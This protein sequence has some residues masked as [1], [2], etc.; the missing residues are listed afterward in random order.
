MSLGIDSLVVFLDLQLVVS[1]LNN[2][3]HVRDPFLHRLFLQVR[4]L[5]HSFHY[6]TFIHIPHLDNWYA[7]SLANQTIDWDINHSIL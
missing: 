4:L 7:D 2:T 1:Q 5:Q 3:Y 6:I